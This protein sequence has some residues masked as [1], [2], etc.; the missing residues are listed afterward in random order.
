MEKFARRCDAT[1]KGMNEGYCFGD[2]EAYFIHESDALE[3]ALKRGYSTL[4]EAYEDDAY[5]YTEWE[6]IDDDIYYDVDGNEYEA[7][8]T[9]RIEDIKNE[10]DAIVSK[11]QECF[12]LLWSNDLEVSHQVVATESTDH[13]DYNGWLERLF[14]LQKK[15]KS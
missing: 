6:E 5:Y 13:V 8:Q 1:G 10:I 12:D 15:L 2:G 3:F 9:V 11:I 14:E 4:D 7:Q